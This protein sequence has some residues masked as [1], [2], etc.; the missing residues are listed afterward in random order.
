MG[1]SGQAD[2]DE[3]AKATE[4]LPLRWQVFCVATEVWTV[5]SRIERRGF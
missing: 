4:Q 2:K 5:G 3:G 1:V